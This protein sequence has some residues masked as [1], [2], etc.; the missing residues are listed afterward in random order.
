MNTERPS[1]EALIR[2]YRGQSAAQEEQL[3][4]LYLSM[5]IDQDYTESCLQEAWNNLN[6]EPPTTRTVDQHRVS[7]EKFQ[8][9]QLNALTSPSKRSFSWYKYAVA[10]CLL[11]IGALG[12]IYLNTK[13]NTP[14]GVTHF[15]A[16]VG[17]RREVRLKDSS[18][19]VLFPGAKLDLASDF[20]DQDR[21]VTLQG[22]AFFQVTHHTDKPFLVASGKLL[23]RVLGTSFEVNTLTPTNTIT[24]RTGKV[25]VGYSGKNVASLIPNQRISYNTQ[26]NTFKI[27]HINA[28]QELSWT[29]GELSY[30]LVPLEIIFEDLEQW[31]GVKI[32]VHNSKFRNKK[33]T[34][35]FKDLPVNQVLDMLSAITGFNYT[36]KGNQITIN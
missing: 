4:A 18:L 5:D 35:S 25:A 19:V 20:N 14:L 32:D 17:E 16:K 1:R 36:I 11:L 10:S 6:E 26:R 2:Y 31:Y 23:T 8:F 28:S 13:M 33:I 27:E 29:A 9:R 15:I 24:L 12:L 7:W 30:D 3:V 21:R 22:R 34:T